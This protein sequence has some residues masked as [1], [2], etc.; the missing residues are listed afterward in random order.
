MP[1]HSLSQI[2]SSA[3]TGNLVDI[4]Y[5]SLTSRTERPAEVRYSTTIY[6]P[7]SVI[8]DPLHLTYKWFHL[9]CKWSHHV[10]GWLQ[11][12]FWVRGEGEVWILAP[13]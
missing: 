2:Q 7:S 5:F 10:T 1:P 3:G 6:I 13:P 4:I 11:P 12:A 9:V 8:S